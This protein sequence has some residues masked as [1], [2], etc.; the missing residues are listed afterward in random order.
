MFH[1]AQE[2]IGIFQILDCLFI[3]E[4][5]IIEMVQI[6]QTLAI[7]QFKFGSTINQ[8]KDL[9]DKFN[10]ANTASTE[11]DIILNITPLDFTLDHGFHFAHGFKSTVIHVFTKDKRTGHV[12]QSITFRTWIDN[13]RLDPGVALPFPA[14][15][16]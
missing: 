3:Q 10:F 11:L 16:T 2:Q 1:P 14:M 8:L 4:F 5:S 13:T 15:L 7:L 6:D 9:H 12:K